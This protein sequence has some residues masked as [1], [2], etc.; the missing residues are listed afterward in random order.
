[1]SD[2]KRLPEAESREGLV[3]TQ[4]VESS[5]GPRYSDQPILPPD[6]SAGQILPP[7]GR[8]PTGGNGF[9]QTLQRS[10]EEARDNASSGDILPPTSEIRPPQSP[11][12]Y[13]Q[14]NDNARAPSNDQ[15][16]ISRLFGPAP[17]AGQNNV[18]AV[19]E[20]SILTKNRS[21]SPATGGQQILPPPRTANNS[22]DN[23]KANE[24]SDLGSRYGRLDEP[25]TP[26]T[27]R[28]LPRTQDSGATTAS[29]P[30]VFN[31]PW[32]PL[33]R[34]TDSPLAREWDT[35]STDSE[36]SSSQPVTSSHPAAWPSADAD[37][38]RSAFDVADRSAATGT[39]TSGNSLSFPASGADRMASPLA[40][41]SSPGEASSPA[42]PEIRSEMLN[43]PANDE[44]VD[45]SG[46]PVRPMQA[47]FPVTSGQPTTTTPQLTVIAQPPV[48][49]TDGNSANT[50]MF[51]LLLAWV[52]LSGS[53][54]GNLYLF[55]S[56]L[57]IR[58]KYRGLVRTA[59]RKLGRRAREAREEDEYDD[60]EDED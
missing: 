47:S 30:G 39:R 45:A 7:S 8:P 25:I 49:A 23:W 17:S 29:T 32:P 28:A 5:A 15:S 42:V 4:Y 20:R 3:E 54:A 26:D 22:A 52:L 16:D 18:Q 44:L 21:D 6:R 36:R 33:D 60:E 14:P 55:W 40:E 53:G 58:H 57:D 35:R 48:T 19:D 59:G 24:T 43:H 12:R 9:G 11:P 50:K 34:F 2:V 51:P 41:A 13:F 46:A 1:V 31:A 56:Y 10:A 37:S 38:S 27:S